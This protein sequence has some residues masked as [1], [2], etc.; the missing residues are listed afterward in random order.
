VPILPKLSEACI[1]KHRVMPGQNP[2][3]TT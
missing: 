2:C 3:Q 1:T